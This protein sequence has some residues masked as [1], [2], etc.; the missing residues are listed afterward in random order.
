[1]AGLIFIAI[2]VGWFFAVRWLAGLVI[3]SI[4]NRGLRRLF[5]MLIVP[6]LF[7]LPVTDEIVGGFQF[8]ALC[9]ENAVV[10]IDAKKIKSKKIRVVI[11]PSDKEKHVENSAVKIY[12]SRYS[13]V[14][15]ETGEELASYSRYTAMGGLLIQMLAMGHEMT[16]MAIHP[17]TCQP[18]NSGNLS[19][20][21]NFQL[22]WN[23][24]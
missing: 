22:V 9:K 5:L 7:I 3:I 4:K 2:L 24:K 8:R 16:P 17:S 13:Y 19:S 11:Y 15:N 10:K 20:D 1:M 23:E 21:F 14:D 12:F 6:L 18:L